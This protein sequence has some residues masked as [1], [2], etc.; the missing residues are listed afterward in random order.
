MA[1]AWDQPELGANTFR[2]RGAALRGDD[3]KNVLRGGW[4][5]RQPHIEQLVAHTRRLLARYARFLK[6]SI[7]RLGLASPVDHKTAFNQKL[8]ARI[9]V[10]TAGLTAI[11]GGELSPRETHR[12]VGNGGREKLHGAGDRNMARRCR[13]SIGC[14][15]G[16]GRCSL[17]FFF[18]KLSRWG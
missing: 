13:R 10:S 5:G 14:L 12:P 4:Q 7:G 6:C 1:A 3:P 16:A 11:Q 18:H 8:S 9:E 15:P 17:D 2:R